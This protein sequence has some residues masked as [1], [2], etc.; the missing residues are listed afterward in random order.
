[1]NTRFSAIRTAHISFVFD[2]VAHWS[3][4][5]LSEAMIFAYAQAVATA[6]AP[7]IGPMLTLMFALLIGCAIA[8]W[9]MLRRQE[10]RT[11]SDALAV[12]L[13]L[14]CFF[15]LSRQTGELFTNRWQSWR[16][17]LSWQQLH[18]SSA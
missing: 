10:R 17:S 1:M 4:R 12:P 9:L 8:P 3:P 14:V 16:R 15:L 13:A 2:R 7:L 11:W 5:Q 6:R 18:S